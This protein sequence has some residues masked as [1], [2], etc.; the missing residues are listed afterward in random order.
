[1]AE[2]SEVLGTGVPANPD[3][4]RGRECWELDSGEFTW[5]SHDEGNYQS[6]AQPHFPDGPNAGTFFPGVASN[7]EPL[8][9]VLKSSVFTVLS[10]RLC[11]DASGFGS[12]YV[13]IDLGDDGHNDIVQIAPGIDSQAATGDQWTEQCVDTSAA[14]GRTAR[15]YLIDN[16]SDSDFAWA[17]WDSFRADSTCPSGVGVPANA[18]FSAEGGA[19]WHLESGQFTWGTED[20]ANHQSNAQP[21]FLSGPNAGTFSP[22][23]PNNGEPQIGV[24]KSSVFRIVSTQLCWSVSGFGS[25]FLALDVDDDGSYDS[26]VVV[27]GIDDQGGPNH[28][29]DVWSD[30]C[31]DTSNYAGAEATIILVD[32]D[33]GTSFAWAAWDEFRAV[34]LISSCEAAGGQSGIKFFAGTADAPQPRRVYCDQDTLGG[35][36]ALAAVVS[37]TDHQDHFGPNSWFSI[38]D[39]DLEGLHAPTPIWTSS[40]VFG[41]DPPDAYSTANSKSVAYSVVEGNE[42][43]VRERQGR[44]VG[45]RAYALNTPPSSLQQLFR[46]ARDHHYFEDR[47]LVTPSG[48]HCTVAEGDVWITSAFMQ[49]EQIDFNYQ[50]I[51]DGGVIST[52][53]SDAENASEA[54]SGLACR[55]DGSCN[56]GY[57]G[58]VCQGGPRHYSNS[59]AD[60][61]HSVALYVR[62]HVDRACPSAVACASLN[63]EACRPRP[64]DDTCP[65][66]THQCGACLPGF[67]ARDDASP[68]SPPPNGD[69]SSPEAAAND[70]TQ[71]TGRSAFACEFAPGDGIGPTGSEGTRM[72]APN[73]AACAAMVRATT[74]VRCVHCCADHCLSHRSLK[75]LC[76]MPVRMLTVPHTRTQVTHFALPSLE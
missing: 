37:N 44:Q 51:N 65:L 16:D 15:I 18:D 75:C 11:W 7:G 76:S 10:A 24:L 12:S 55:V 1:M 53:P 64:V 3:F 20:D 36:W 14:I 68:C 69:G 49:Y 63:R 48:R 27:S 62:P 56:F 29:G 54:S 41:D 50:L 52:D 28:P 9:G 33:T 71:A 4:S 43:L 26:Q 47:V 25:S 58:N 34:G 74:P 70:C 35:G 45:F 60:Q 39:C 73:A 8:T 17:A 32:D 6:N 61:E 23:S 13:A 57:D 59:A 72:D 40:A 67:Y 42:L 5:G 2:C 19:C 22:G 46:S 38:N 30:Q 21:Q 66:D 31:L